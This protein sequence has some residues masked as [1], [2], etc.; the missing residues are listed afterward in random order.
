MYV[1]MYIYIYIYKSVSKSLSCIYLYKGN[2]GPWGTGGESNLHGSIR[3]LGPHFR[4]GALGPESLRAGSLRPGSLRPMG[5]WAHGWA[6]RAP[7]GITPWDPKIL[8]L[9]SQGE[10]LGIPGG[11]PRGGTLGPPMGPWAHWPQGPG[12]QGP[13]PQGL[14]AQGPPTEMGAQGPNTTMK[15]AL[16]PSAPRPRIPFIE[17]YTR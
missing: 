13:S 14:G 2:S 6:Q 4:G 9:G 5:P 17:I 16:P 12:P 8:P 3:P 15:V 7:P 10:Y 1:C 11:D